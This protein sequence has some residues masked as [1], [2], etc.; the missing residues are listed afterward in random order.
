MMLTVD[1]VVRSHFLVGSLDPI[2][3][4]PRS[5][6]V[7]LADFFLLLPGQSLHLLLAVVS[8]LSYFHPVGG[9]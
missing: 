7:I 8:V 6:L 1:L 5:M 4:S 3:L 2:L 9:C